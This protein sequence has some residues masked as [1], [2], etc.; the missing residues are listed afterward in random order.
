MHASFTPT[1]YQSLTNCIND[2]TN[3][4]RTAVMNAKDFKI[5][6]VIGPR[7]EDSGLAVR[8]AKGI[9]NPR[10]K[11]PRLSES[12]STAEMESIKHVT[13]KERKLQEVNAMAKGWS[14][15]SSA[16]SSSTKPIHTARSQTAAD[17]VMSRRQKKGSLPTQ[18]WRD[19]DGGRGDGDTGRRT[20]PQPPCDV[21]QG[22]C[23]EQLQRRP[24]ESGVALCGTV[25]SSICDMMQSTEPNQLPHKRSRLEHS[26]PV[27]TSDRT[28][29]T[30]RPVDASLTQSRPRST[31]SLP[32]PPP[33]S[34]PVSLQLVHSQRSAKA[35]RL[36]LEAAEDPGIPFI[37][38]V[39][40]SS[41]LHPPTYPT[42]LHLTP[43]SYPSPLTQLCNSPIVMEASRQTS[44]SSSG[45]L[46]A[47]PS[48]T[49]ETALSPPTGTTARGWGG[50]GGGSHVKYVTSSLRAEKQLGRNVFANATFAAA[51]RHR[52]SGAETGVGRRQSLLSECRIKSGG[53]TGITARRPSTRYERLWDSFGLAVERDNN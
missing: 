45:A 28:A 16:T 49:T 31:L 17:I 33:H 30:E 48:L 6:D 15:A 53:G 29:E 47:A 21:A 40:P 8:I 39:L 20:S 41:L 51:S 32:V 2:G 50:G 18:T 43:A 3:S 7:T 1:D 36:C 14:S 44:G 4:S 5:G 37:D 25:P 35:R 26:S 11:Q 13:E 24:K 38:G 19:G 22:Q 46:A 12:F 10:T 52:S 34:L 9:I 42:P 27:G 23:Y